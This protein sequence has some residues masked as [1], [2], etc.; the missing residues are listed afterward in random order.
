MT[1]LSVEQIRRFR[2]AVHHLDRVYANADIPA[3]V[4]A[5][6]MQN[7]PP[8]AW[9]TALFNRVPGC[10]QAE[11]ERLLYEEKVL[12]QAW[13]MRGAPLV[14]PV[15]ES[16]TFL[17]ALIA[18][19]GEPWIYTQ[20][21]ALALDYL[22]M[23]FEALLEQMVQVMTQ[24]DGRLIL[25]KTALDQ[26]I[27]DWMLPFLP[28][29]KRE[30][31]NQPSMYG[32]PDKQTVGGAAVSFLLRPC[33]YLGLVVFGERY[34]ISPTFTSYKTWMG[35]ELMADHHEAAST[36]VRKYLHCYGPATPDMFVTWL[37]CSRK[38]GRRM[39]E[40]A[41][42]DMEPV[43]VLGKRAFIL[44]ADRNQFGLPG[45]LS[46]ELLLLGGHDPFLDQRDRFILQPDKSLHKQIW[47]LVTN[48]GAIVCRGEIIGV[49]T[50]KK[51]GNRG[52]E[53]KMT[54]WAERGRAM[55]QELEQLAV[56][57]AAF[58]GKELAGI[59]VE[60]PR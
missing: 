9:E 1:E 3:V 37:G 18:G 52:L 8:G 5:C 39:W 16:R 19:E 40:L 21:I 55:R 43:S 46:R 51:S 14:F 12:L 17:S 59:V 13:S 47:K 53:F 29:E 41:A 23:D 30:L 31:W 22:Q 27:A 25:S 34:G 20:G 4:G 32:S 26:T 10:S 7:S 50:G 44:S 48:P 11:M 36:L 38:Q 33:A 49:W 54:L 60:E 35:H 58:R 57:Y 45:E 24:L 56:E 42:Q 2:L 28:E 15:S 6:G